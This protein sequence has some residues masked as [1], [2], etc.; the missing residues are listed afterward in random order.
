M[1]ERTHK[2]G[3]KRLRRDLREHAR[4]RLRAAGL[5]VTTPRIEV[6]LCLSARDQAMTHSEVADLLATADFDAATVYRNLV[7]LTESGVVEVISRAGGMAR[8]AIRST[9]HSEHGEHVHFFCTDCGTVS[10]LPEEATPQIE[11]S[12]KWRAAVQTAQ[13]QLEGTCPTCLEEPT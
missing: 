8:Y 1:T 13:L 10:C 5:R 7:K 12:G 4:D 11:V 9:G 3:A 2:R 6:L